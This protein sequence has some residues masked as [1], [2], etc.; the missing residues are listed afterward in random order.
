LATGDIFD[1]FSVLG[2]DERR[3]LAIIQVAGFDLPTIQLG[4]SNEIK[5]GESVIAI[6]SPLGLQGTVTTGIVSSIRDIP[7]NTGFKV[8]QTDAPV[9]PGNSSG[10]LVNSDGKAIG[11]VSAK[12]RGAEGLN[13]AVPINYVR[14]MLNNL[15]T[16]I[17]LDEMRMR[18]GRAPDV[19][20]VSAYPSRWK[21][22][23]TGTVRQLRFEGDYIYGEIIL[24]EELRQRGVFT[25]Y[26]PRKDGD[27]YIGIIRG[28]LACDYN[29][30]NFQAP[31]EL[32][33]VS[34]TRI[35]GK[36][37]QAPEGAK[38]NCRKCAYSKAL[39]W[40]EFVWIPE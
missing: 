26:E 13:F 12:I 1:S 40:V 37:K 14:G 5:V 29:A 3:D 39:V 10:P 17:S 22:L 4:N 23:L 18:L 2:F 24:P 35:E 25:S 6:G 34:P 28:R 7:G 27:K 20:A 15:Q 38:F 19:F 36:A 21:S 33:V 16:P 30:C 8:I 32:R 31:I 11:V 9:N